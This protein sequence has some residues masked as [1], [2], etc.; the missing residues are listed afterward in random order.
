MK[1]IT[2]LVLTISLI[3]VQSAYS[4]TKKEDF[5]FQEITV[6]EA[7][8]EQKPQELTHKVD[9]I[10]NKEIE[11]LNLPNRNLSELIKYTPGNFV[12]PLS[13]NDAN[14][15]S[16]GGLGP[17]YNGWL[18][19]GLPIDSF[20]DPMSLDFIYLDRVE[21]HRGPASVLYPNYMTMD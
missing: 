9:V 14:W 10:D 13:R 8:I 7:K 2:L 12:N 16:Y 19:D 1:I 5:K 18:L 21:V 17:K 4:E 15:G 20:V 11:N 3:F 6:T